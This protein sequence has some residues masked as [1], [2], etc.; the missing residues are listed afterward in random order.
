MVGIHRKMG[1]TETSHGEVDSAPLLDSQN[2]AAGGA[3]EECL[4]G[5]AGKQAFHFAVGDGG[6][7]ERLAALP[8]HAH[9]S[10]A[11]EPAICFGADGKIR[12][13]EK[14]EECAHGPKERPEAVDQAGQGFVRE[15][16]HQVPAEDRGQG[17]SG[18]RRQLGQEFIDEEN[19]RFPATVE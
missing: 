8:A 15:Q 10:E 1:R 18:Y 13:A 3:R 19:R 4:D 7:S 17:F 2:F 12:L 16:V 11:F 6:I 5:A 14:A 9:L